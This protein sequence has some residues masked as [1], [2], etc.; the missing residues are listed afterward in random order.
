[1]FLDIV[2]AARRGSSMAVDKMVRYDDHELV[3]RKSPGMKGF[4]VLLTLLFGS[5]ESL[6]LQDISQVVHLPAPEAVD[7]VAG[8]S[9]LLLVT[10]LSVGLMLPESLRIRFA[11]H[12]YHLLTPSDLVTLRWGGLLGEL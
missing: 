8:F 10:V 6:V 5:L 9:L 3:L 1:L 4:G 2:L 12:S 7:E 11:D